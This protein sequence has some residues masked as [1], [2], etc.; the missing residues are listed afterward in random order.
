MKLVFLLEEPSM[1]F[2]LDGILPR[3]LPPDVSFQTIPH[4]GKS[5]LGKSIPIKLRA[6]NEPDV[7][8]VVVHD[9]DSND[10]M[11]LKQKL[12]DLCTGFGKRFLVR[13]P[14]HELEAWY[15][16]DL[17]AVSKAYD[18]DLTA[19]SSRKTYR[20]PDAIE[21]PKKELKRFLPQ[22]GQIEGAKRIAPHMN[23]QANTSHSFGVFVHGV[24]N[25]CQEAISH[26]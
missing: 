2:L 20:I 14:C 3:I 19:L 9:Q 4:Q 5:D 7:A 24:Q 18:K 1:K 22:L 17:D 23:I 26:G 8:F 10:C 15:W 21:N 25:L 6:W 16:G 13:I 12:T 11:V